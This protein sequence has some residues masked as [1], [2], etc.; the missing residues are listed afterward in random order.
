MLQYVGALSRLAR[1]LKVPDAKA[2]SLL[3][4]ATKLSFK[5]KLLPDGHGRAWDVCG[6][7]VKLRP[8]VSRENRECQQPLT[9]NLAIF[10][11]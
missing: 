7:K 11:C 4:G 9:A 10:F 6:P 8:P 1:N 5:I 3:S 2:D